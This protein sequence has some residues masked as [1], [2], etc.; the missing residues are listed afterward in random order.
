MTDEA[1]RS[2]STSGTATRAR[3]PSWTGSAPRGRSTRWSASTAARRRRT[4]SCSATGGTT[5]SPSSGR[6]RSA[7]GARRTC[8]GSWWST[9]WRW[10]PRPT[11][12]PRSACPTRSDRLTV[13]ARRA[14]RHAVPPGGEPGARAGPGRRPARLVRHGRRRDRWRTRWPTR[15]TRPGSATA[16]RPRVLRR[17]LA[18]LRDRLAAELARS[19][20]PPVDATACEAYA[21]FA[22]AVRHRG[23]ATCRAAAGRGR[24]SSR[25]R[26]GCCWTSGTASTRTRPGARRRSPTP[27]RCWPRRRTAPARL[28]RAAHASPPGTAPGRWSPRTRRCTLRR[29]PHNGHGPVAGRVPGR[30]LRRGRPPLRP[31]GRRRRRRARPHPPRR[32]RSNPA[33]RMCV[34]Y[35]GT[36]PTRGA[37]GDLDRQ[38][39]LTAPLLASRPRLVPVSRVSVSGFP[40]FSASPVL[41]LPRFSGFLSFS[42]FLVRLD[43][44]GLRRSWRRPWCSSRGGRARR[45][46]RPPIRRRFRAPPS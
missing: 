9:R 20:A 28:G 25:A 13:D 17:K 46:R 45:T 43:G 27:R 33:L 26:R 44:G 29:D 18:A 42:S 21:A 8:P 34:D 37:T 2:S 7:R 40:G 39:R 15:T 6:A 5:R 12:W 16:A 14:A 23:P 24:A 1:R 19:T 31:G 36:V 4:T 35:D 3:A 22:A 10:P 41:R 30:P 32:R 38:E 11:T